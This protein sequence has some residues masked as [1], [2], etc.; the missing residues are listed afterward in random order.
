MVGSYHGRNTM[1]DY[2][3]PLKDPQ[4]DAGRF[5]RCMRGQER[6]EKPPLVEYLVD[7]VVM[8]PIVTELLGRRWA[9]PQED[10]ESRAAYWDNF[11][12]FWY[13][14]GYDFVRMELSLPFRVNR[15]TI[16][17]AAPQSEGDRAWADEHQGTIMTWQ[18]FE[19]YDWPSVTE[20]DYFPYEYVDSHLPDG[21]GL[22]VSHAGGMYE[23]LSM[24]MSYEGLCWAL[25]DTP[26][27][28]E[29][30]TERVG[31]LMEGYYQRLLELDN[32]IA[33]FPG[34]DM[35]FRTGTLIGPDHLRAH[36]LPWHRR[37]AEMAHQRGLPYF[38]HSCGNLEAIM[39]DLIEDVGIDGKHSFE[40][41]ILPVLE[42][43]RRYGDHIAVLGGV[44][45]HVLSSAGPDEVRRH[46][47]DII[48]ACAPAGRFAL[49][50][51]NSIPSYVP[52][53]NYLTMLDEAL[54]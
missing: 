11:I 38:L 3:V 10:R 5:I 13:R 23:H 33:L 8:R 17:D 6:D 40:N 36:T 15:I 16:Q 4:P 39:P 25:Y 7:P 18:D 1:Q 32:L 46:V 44:D 37:F 47:R 28:V 35:G 2:R 14:M 43:Q 19:R 49:G 30:I 42:F 45:V 41:A 48:D 21:M 52:V 22:I 24:I 27:L 53:E 51:G 20:A 54:R 26:D 12:E 31:M 29:A 9:T 50:S 34:D